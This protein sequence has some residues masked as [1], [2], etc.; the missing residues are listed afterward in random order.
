MDANFPPKGRHIKLL[1]NIVLV[2]KAFEKWKMCVDY[3]DLNIECPKDLYSLLNIDKLVEILTEYKC[4][5][6][7][8]AY[9]SYNQ[10]PMYE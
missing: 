7:M 6:F 9:S 3:T 8:G 5:S 1:S 4:L 10:M 2:K